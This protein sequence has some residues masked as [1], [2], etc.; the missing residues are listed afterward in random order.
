[1]DFLEILY[2][3]YASA[4]E[5]AAT[6]AVGL[7]ALVIARRQTDI[8]EKQNSLQ[9]HLLALEQ[10]RSRRETVE[11]AESLYATFAQFLFDMFLHGVAETYPKIQDLHDFHEKTDYACDFLLP[12][13]ITDFRNTALRHAD[14]LAQYG[15]FLA[16]SAEEK[17]RFSAD[18]P[19][20]MQRAINTARSFFE[21]E[22][23]QGKLKM[24][25]ADY[26]KQTR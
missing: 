25:F 9:E 7:A 12:K 8:I 15:Y 10:R 1:M 14:A 6:L 26:L 19:Q 4:L 21:S 5:A 22:A 20:E 16:A 18:Q 3:Q 23:E 13:D 2:T 24:L 17:A 11:K